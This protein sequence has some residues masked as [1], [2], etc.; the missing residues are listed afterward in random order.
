M[1]HANIFFENSLSSQTNISRN[2]PEA[3]SVEAVVIPAHTV[4]WEAFSV[5]AAVIP[6]HTVDW[7]AF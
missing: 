5:E 2:K 4:D 1:Y 6:A 3:F 7:E